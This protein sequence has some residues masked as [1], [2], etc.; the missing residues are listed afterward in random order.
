MIVYFFLNFKEGEKM[1]FIVDKM[2]YS[3]STC[4]F[5]K[6]IPNPPFI[7]EPGYWECKLTGKKCSFHESECDI[8]KEE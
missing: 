6:W 8:L 2:P 4:M 7:E 3:S 1:K 5:S